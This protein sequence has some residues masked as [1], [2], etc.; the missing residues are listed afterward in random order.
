MKS[1][2]PYVPQPQ[3]VR[4]D[5]NG[6]QA[7][8]GAGN[9]RAEKHAEEW[10][11]Q[12][13]R[14]GNAQGVVDKSEEQILP[15]V[16]HRRAA[17]TNRLGDP[18]KIAFD[19]RDARA[20]H[21]HVGAGAHRNPDFGFAQGGRIVDAV[22]GHR[23]VLALAPQLLDMG[24]F[25]GGFNFRFNGVD[26]ERFR[27]RGGGAAVVAGQHHD[28]QTECVKLA[29]GLGGGG[30]DRIGDGDDARRLAVN[31]DEHRRL[32]FFLKFRGRCFERLQARNFF[33]SQKGRL[34]DHD[35]AA[36]DGADD[37]A[38]RDRAKVS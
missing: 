26:A 14:H 36:G 25:S 29:D 24:H 4:D 19:Q 23:D 22:A 37:T 21:G 7:H 10:I 33:I 15:D 11:E 20:L 2:Q 27:D 3:R 13:G 32:T 30:L 34:A 12:P 31:R 38:R 5:R 8:R 17:K 16:P 18:A 9:D 1:L 35:H 28:A 6:T